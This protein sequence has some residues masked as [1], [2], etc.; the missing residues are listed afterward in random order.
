MPSA[1]V[2]PSFIFLIIYFGS[3]IMAFSTAGA[4]NAGLAIQFILIAR[5]A[6]VIYNGYIVALTKR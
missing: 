5:F 1:I 6:E 2:V 3:G 4:G